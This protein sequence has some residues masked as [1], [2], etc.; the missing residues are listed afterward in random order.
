MRSAGIDVAS[1]G[2]AAIG[3]CVNGKPKRHAVWKPS[4]KKNSAAVNL[5]EQYDWLRFHIGLM[6]PDVIAVEEL[7]VFLNK[8]VIRALARHEG[9]ALLAAKQSGAVVISPIVTQ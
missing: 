4:H 3:L 1:S 7:A 8:T 2:L 6:R 5:L 9:I